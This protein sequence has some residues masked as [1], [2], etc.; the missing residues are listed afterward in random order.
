MT[1]PINSAEDLA[2][3]NFNT[4]PNAI[5]YG[6]SRSNIASN[7]F[8]AR[9]TDESVTTM[10]QEMNRLDM[11]A[12]NT[13]DG[14]AKARQG[15]YVYMEQKTVVDFANSRIPCNTKIV[16]L[17]LY[18]DRYAIALSSDAQQLRKR[19]SNLILDM[20]EHN[21]LRQIEE[22]WF[23]KPENSTSDL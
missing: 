9:A 11:M 20:S 8:F 1:D 2:R 12:N 17:P 15:N 16:G 22:K 6:I 5:R 14:V 13:A 3:Q 23:V 7:F 19:L 4:T 10:W 21:E 18:Y